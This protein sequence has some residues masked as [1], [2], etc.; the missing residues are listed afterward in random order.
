[1]AARYPPL[2]AETVGALLQ[3]VVR[4]RERRHQVEHR[5]TWTTRLIAGSRDVTGVANIA[6]AFVV[7]LVIIP[8]NARGQTSSSSRPLSA[9]VVG[10]YVARDG[11]LTLLVLWRGSPGWYS[12]GGGNSSS[13]GGGGSAGGREVGSFSMT[14]SG[15]TLSIDFDY[16]ARV[17]RLL[18][19]E[20]SLADTNVVLVD[21]VDGSSGAH[22][23]GRLWVEPK[24]P[25]TDSSRPRTIEDDPAITAIRRAPEAGAF[26]Q[27]DIPLSLPTGSRCLRGRPHSPRS[28]DQY[29]QGVL[30]QICRAAI[31]P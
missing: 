23:V 10:T 20:I 8:W 14:F 22:I 21:E 17:A 13:G 16:T 25:E 3:K 9:T 29:M 27:C 19:Q 7:M 30:T 12:G 4:A 26:L 2:T 15:R 31:G 6:V 1:M 5:F 18:E 24:L 11:E 28:A